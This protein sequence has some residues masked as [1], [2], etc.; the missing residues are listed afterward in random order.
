M[1]RIKFS[2]IPSEVNS[3][4]AALN[5][6]KMASISSAISNIVEHSVK[7]SAPYTERMKYINLVNLVA[8]KYL[9]S[10]TYTYG[11]AFHWVE[12]EVDESDL[13]DTLRELYLD[14]D[15][16]LW[17]VDQMEDASVPDIEVSEDK[18]VSSETV[19]KSKEVVKTETQKEIKTEEQVIYDGDRILMA[20]KKHSTTEPPRKKPPT[21]GRELFLQTVWKDGT[22][23]TFQRTDQTLTLPLIPPTDYDKMFWDAEDW[24][25]R[26]MSMYC[27]LPLIPQKQKDVSVTTNPNLMIDRDFLNLYPKKIIRIRNERMYYT[28]ITRNFKGEEVELDIDELL[29]Y[30]PKITGYTR[31][32]VIDNIVKYPTFGYWYRDTKGEWKRPHFLENIEMD[33]ELLPFAEWYDKY[34]EVNDDLKNLPGHVDF[35][36]DYIFRKY[37]LDEEAGIKHK[38]PIVGSFGPFLTLWAPPYIYEQLGYNDILGMA[39]QCVYNRIDFYRTRNPVF[40]HAKEVEETGYHPKLPERRYCPFCA[41]CDAPVC[42][43]S[44]NRTSTL[45]SMMDLSELE[46]TKFGEIPEDSIKMILDYMDKFKGK[47]GMVLCNKNSKYL[48]DLYTWVAICKL[49]RFYGS[50]MTVFELDFN[51]YMQNMRSG[52]WGRGETERMSDVRYLLSTVRVLVITGLE[53]IQWYDME[54]Q[55]LMNLIGDR[56]RSTDFSTVIVSRHPK[57][58]MGAYTHRPFAARTYSILEEILAGKKNRW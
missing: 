38:Y 14:Q 2:E 19:S 7:V 42:D 16:V 41:A 46:P 55:T 36:Y 47:T 32:Q 23:V 15:R 39:K 17:D 12:E 9:T 52:N 57:D 24:C 18:V 31:E 44:C 11:S 34:Y 53:Y 4:L 28:N 43:Y 49:A 26:D 30:I 25:G 5:P 10:P 48:A 50:K 13:K 51:W 6:S 54:S 35:I 21:E 58:F 1:G 22:P 20:M 29:G 45:N 40:R 56:E 33:G 3:I 8:Y 37:V 27:T